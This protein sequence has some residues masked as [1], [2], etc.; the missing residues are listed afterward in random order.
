MHPLQRM[1]LVTALASI[2]RRHERPLPARVL[3]HLSL[4]ACDAN[5]VC[6]A[7]CPTG[8]LQKLVP[9]ADRAELRFESL[10]CIAC[11]Q[12]ARVCPERSLRLDVQG[13]EAK[14]VV[15]AAW[16]QRECVRCGSR[17]F[18]SRR[19]RRT[20]ERGVPVFHLS[21]DRSFI[22]RR[23]GLP[24]SDPWF[25]CVTTL[26]GVEDGNPENQGNAPALFAGVGCG[27]RSRRRL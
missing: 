15:L 13:G 27:R 16:R 20:G 22:P 8:A 14:P 2:A 1:R 25:R 7:V 5:G 17:L 21:Q 11:N 6:A 3:P 18:R 19:E 23:R 10:R 4:G 12:C 9:A 24:A 26:G